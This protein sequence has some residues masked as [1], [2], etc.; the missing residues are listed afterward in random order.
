MSSCT[1]CGCRRKHCHT[2]TPLQSLCHSFAVKAQLAAH[3]KSQ[4]HKDK[5]AAAT[6]SE[7]SS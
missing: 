6:E 2:E 5:A 1:W 3:Y 4:K 7:S